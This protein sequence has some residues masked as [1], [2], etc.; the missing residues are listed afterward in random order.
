[1]FGIGDAE[2]SGSEILYPSEQRHQIN[3]VRSTGPR[4]GEMML[5]SGATT[6]VAPPGAFAESIDR[7]WKPKL[8]DVQGNPL[9]V[10]GTQTADTRIGEGFKIP[11]KVGFKVAS[12]TDIVLSTASVLDNGS[13]IHLTRNHGCWIEGDN[14]ER[15]TV[16]RK[17]HRFYV[18]FETADGGRQNPEFVA[19]VGGAAS[20]SSAA[21]PA[22]DEEMS[23]SEV[24]SD[25]D[26]D[27]PELVGPN[28]ILPDGT[29]L[30]DIARAVQPPQPLFVG[31][32]REPTDAERV[33][34]NLHHGNSV[35]WC[36]KCV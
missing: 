35:P 22:D 24:D 1:M 15:I 26:Q 8:Y 21:N 28:Q 4:R 16:V 30:I 5:D 19:P 36:E 13:D 20:S 2:A 11:A 17:G 32:P 33:A 10:E 18:P 23:G 14:G 27:I 34:H 7:T 29:K 25:S 6:N 3:A 31:E 12:T 9:R